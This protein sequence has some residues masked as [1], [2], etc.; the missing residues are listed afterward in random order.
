M[1]GK[2][3]IN[4]QNPPRPMRGRKQKKHVELRSSAMKQGAPAAVTPAGAAE[5]HEVPE[6][7]AVEHLRHATGGE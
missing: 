6:G 1:D 2:R 5:Q 4:P 7:G 3:R